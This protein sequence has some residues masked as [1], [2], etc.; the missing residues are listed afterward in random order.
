MR[1]HGSFDLVWGVFLWFN[2]GMLA[3][4]IYALISGSQPENYGIWGL[5]GIGLPAG[6][7]GVLW[8]REA[9]GVADR[10]DWVFVKIYTHGAKPVNADVLLGQAMNETLTYLERVYNDGTQW[11]LHYVTARE[12]YN[13]I[14]AAERGESGRP[15][16]Y[17]DYELVPG[18]ACR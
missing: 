4:W 9:I 2:A 7:G 10:P 15:A 17:R 6:L 8:V 1:C 16:Q 12:M 14:R 13:T 5:A 18:E 3:R 11:Q